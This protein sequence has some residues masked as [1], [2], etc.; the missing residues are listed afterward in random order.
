MAESLTETPAACCRLNAT[1]PT[2]TGTCCHSALVMRMVCD[3]R[4]KFTMAILCDER[5]KLLISMNRCMIWQRR[6][7]PRL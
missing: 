5:T 2:V 6:T 3:D 1:G 7:D 4:Q